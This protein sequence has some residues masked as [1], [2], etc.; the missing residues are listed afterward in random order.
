LKLWVAAIGAALVAGVA[1]YAKGKAAE[2][3]KQELKAARSYRTTVERMQDAEAAMGDDPA[4]LRD[5][6][7]E[8]DPDQR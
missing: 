7:R 2:R 6:M 3:A 8:R 5:R 4:V 1:I